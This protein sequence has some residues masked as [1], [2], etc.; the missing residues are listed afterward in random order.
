M[1][2][3]DTELTRLVDEAL[4]YGKRTGKKEVGAIWYLVGRL[5]MD[6]PIDY[7][8]S[9]PVEAEESVGC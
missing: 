2:A 4:Q 5:G 1:N 7:F 8:D 3:L 6:V 9:D